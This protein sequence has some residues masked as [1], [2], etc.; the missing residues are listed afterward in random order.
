MAVWTAKLVVRDEAWLREQWLHARPLRRTYGCT[1]ARLL[2][3]ATEPNT[4]L[5][6]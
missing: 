6:F 1:S 3:H 4:Y 5:V 2:R